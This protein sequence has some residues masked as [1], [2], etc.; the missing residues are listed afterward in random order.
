MQR[1][2]LIMLPTQRALPERKDNC[3]SR[4]EGPRLLSYGSVT[5][6]DFRR[7]FV[8]V[9]RPRCPRPSP[10]SIKGAGEG[11]R[12]PPRNGPEERRGALAPG[13]GR[14]PLGERPSPPPGDGCTP[15]RDD[16]ALAP[17]P[18]LTPSRPRRRRRGR[19]PR[20]SAPHGHEAPRDA[21]VR[22]RNPGWGDPR[23]P[24]PNTPSLGPPRA[25][26]DP[27]GPPGWGEVGAYGCQNG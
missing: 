5:L 23:R 25:L 15:A 21:E 24:L 12:N 16:R 13:H 3:Q 27:K 10:T 14:T 11:P 1:F 17:P 8:F 9:G 19:R 18:H 20:Q 4:D 22:G 26:K 6:W 7:P 2:T